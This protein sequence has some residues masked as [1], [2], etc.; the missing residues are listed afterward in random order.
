MLLALSGC[1]WG[2]QLTGP[3]V[4][5]EPPQGTELHVE[6]LIG[7]TSCTELLRWQV[8]E[9]EERVEIHPVL[10]RADPGNCTDDIGGETHVGRLEDPLESE[11]S[12]AA[13]A[14][15]PTWRT[16]PRATLSATAVTPRWA[17][18]PSLARVD[19][20]PIAVPHVTVEG[21]GSSRAMQVTGYVSSM[22]R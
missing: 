14:T 3:W 15:I 19:I 17:H 6:A 4:L 22:G 16:T 7:G 8:T 21:G 18:E 2:N 9:T 1:T 5:A 13:Q 20:A 10:R 12:P 11:T